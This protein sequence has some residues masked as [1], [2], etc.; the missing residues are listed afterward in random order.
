MIL[1]NGNSLIAKALKRGRS[2]LN[3]H[4]YDIHPIDSYCWDHQRALLGDRES[5]GT[6]KYCVDK[7]TGTV[8]LW[9]FKNTDYVFDEAPALSEL[10]YLRCHGYI[11]TIDATS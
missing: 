8:Y 3:R 4:G 9:L 10:P 7:V 11:C 6:L 5:L 1:T 2:A